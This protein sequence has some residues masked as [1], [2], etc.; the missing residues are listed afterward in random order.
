MFIYNMF[1]DVLMDRRVALEQN[2]EIP[3]THFTPI[4]R[5]AKHKTLEGFYEC[6][7]YW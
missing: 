1:R 3:F 7:L 4:V 2:T 5:V 6:P